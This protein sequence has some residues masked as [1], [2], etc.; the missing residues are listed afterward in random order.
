MITASIITI[1]NEL[2]RGRTVNTNATAISQKLTARGL[3]VL[4]HTTVPDVIDDIVFAMKAACQASEYVFVIGGLGPTND[5]I[6]RFAVAKF[7]ETPLEL[8]TECAEHIRNFF[9]IRNIPMPQNNLVQAQIPSDAKV[10]E[11]QLGTANGFYSVKNDVNV[12][13]LPGPPHEMLAVYRECEPFLPKTSH[14]ATLILNFIG[15]S[16]SQLFDFVSKN[17]DSA[18]FDVGY[19]PS[20]RGI[21]LCI[22]AE[23]Q[24]TIDSM[25]KTLYACLGDKIFAEG[26]N[27][28]I[29]SAVGELLC[30]ENATFAVAESCTGGLLGA[31]ITAIP[32]SSRY[33]NGGA[34]VYSNE[35]KSRVLGVD[36]AL[37]AQYG[38]VS[39]ECAKAMALAARKTFMTSFALAITGIAGPEGGSELKPVGTVYIAC[40]TDEYV[41]A[42]RY[43]FAGDRNSIRERAATTAL[44]LLFASLKH[45]TDEKYFADGGIF[46]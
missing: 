5:D 15:I 45:F 10:L 34:I 31:R 40:A 35:A 22:F 21:Q 9:A 37:V 29:E 18:L 20:L 8:S 13:V 4:G 3:T 43:R 17:F 42:R 16:E 44:Y 2:L 12:F 11:N 32:G 24:A 30:S 26:E 23:K 25:R 36:A 19:Y 1:G 41:L 28:S 33:F 14:K 46:V 27:C 7:L 6:T 38:A 39:A